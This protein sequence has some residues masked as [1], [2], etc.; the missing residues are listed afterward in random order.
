MCQKCLCTAYPFKVPPKIWPETY[1]TATHQPALPE[2]K[3]AES[4]ETAT[5][6]WQ[7]HSAEKIFPPK[8]AASAHE[9]RTMY[10][11][12]KHLGAVLD[13]NKVPWFLQSGSLLGAVRHGGVMCH[14]CDVDI[15]IPRQFAY[16]VHGEGSDVRRELELELGLFVDM[17]SSSSGF[18]ACSTGGAALAG[19]PVSI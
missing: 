8:Q 9:S 17:A 4:P 3:T 12:V 1:I 11:I 14:E 6:W 7:E 18:P 16:L 5:P 2:A 13:K 19:S 10:S 15:V